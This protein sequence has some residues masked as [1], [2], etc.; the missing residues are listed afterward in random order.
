MRPY[1]PTSRFQSL[2]FLPLSS[3]HKSQNLERCTEKEGEKERRR[4]ERLNLAFREWSGRCLET[5][6]ILFTAGRFQ[7]EDRRELAGPPPERG[8]CFSFLSA[9]WTPSLFHLC[10]I[11][12]A[13]PRRHRR[14]LQ[15]NTFK[16]R[17]NTSG[18][19]TTEA[20]SWWKNKDF[21][22]F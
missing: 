11:C 16:P 10:R 9:P 15:I 4:G 22:E 20:R 2:S 17:A 6:H 14:R 18:V 13:S 19:A 3:H 8:S 1:H 7:P 5:F 12:E 21:S